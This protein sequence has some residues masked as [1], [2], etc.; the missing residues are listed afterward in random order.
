LRKAHEI[1][2]SGL[3]ITDHDTIAA[4]TPQLF[5]LADELKIR[6]LPG[7]ELS[8]EW[9]GASVH[10]LGYGI[11]IHSEH[12]KSFLSEMIRRRNLRNQAII[13][14][15]KARNIAIEMEELYRLS[16]HQTIG[17]PH[18]AALLLRKGVVVSMQEAFQVYLGEGASCYSLGIKY[19][20][21]EVIDAIHE[22]KGKAVLA[23]PHFTKVSHL[24]QL[25]NLPLDGLECYYGTLHKVQERPWL[26]KAKKRGLIPTGGSDYHGH[27]KPH[28]SLGCSWVDEK[29]FSLLTNP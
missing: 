19:T 14:K 23:H 16:L 13:D 1:G 20:P 17:R 24:R 10:I 12:L 3:S 7:I 15:L 28:V 8:S 4:Y 22:A 21:S 5:V 6:L 9:E 11:D 27:F 2:L 26:D 18:I 29:T 25:L